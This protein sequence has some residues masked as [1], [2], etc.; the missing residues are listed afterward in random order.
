MPDIKN[1][2]RDYYMDGSC[3]KKDF[4]IPAKEGGLTAK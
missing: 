4:T 2:Q 1:W 3:S